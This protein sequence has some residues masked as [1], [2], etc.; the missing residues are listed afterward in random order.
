MAYIEVNPIF[1]ELKKCLNTLIE[2]KTFVDLISHKFRY[3][4][5]SN[6]L[7]KYLDLNERV[8][9][10]V[11]RITRASDAVTDEVNGQTTAPQPEVE[12][13]ERSED[14]T[15]QLVGY[16]G[17]A[18]VLKVL[19]QDMDCNGLPEQADE[20]SAQHWPS[21][22]HLP[23]S[24]DL[25][26]FQCDYNGCDKQ[27]A[28]RYRLNSHM[29]THQ[30]SGRRFGC[31]WPGCSRSFRN[32]STLNVHTKEHSGNGL[33]RCHWIGCDRTF[34]QGEQLKYHVNKHTGQRPYLCQWPGCQSAF[35]NKNALGVHFKR[36]QGY[37]YSCDYDNCYYQTSDSVHMKSHK[38]KH[39]HED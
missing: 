22:D 21:S 8:E 33:Y 9:T 13:E 15:N 29:K 11:K 38:K 19:K 16:S 36:H 28:T 20:E 4:L 10:S 14:I 23:P 6:E 32:K 37:T 5:D 25:K 26:I 17:E 1:D 31:Q 18:V 24:I 39:H 34:K 3:E 27:F 12:F 2:F 35:A 7:Q 30:E